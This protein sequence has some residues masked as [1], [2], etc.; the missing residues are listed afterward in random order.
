MGKTTR[1]TVISTYENILRNTGATVATALDLRPRMN[2]AGTGTEN[3]FTIMPDSISNGLVVLRVEGAPNLLS[4]QIVQFTNEFGNGE[5]GTCD[6][7]LTLRDNTF[8]AQNVEVDR[9]GNGTMMIL[10]IHGIMPALGGKC[11]GLQIIRADYL[12]ASNPKCDHPKL[13]CTADLADYWQKS[14]PML[15]WIEDHPNNIMPNVYRGVGVKK[16]AGT[17]QRVYQMLGPG[18]VRE[19][20][21]QTVCINWPVL[22]RKMQGTGTA[23]AFV[24]DD[25]GIAISDEAIGTDGYENLHTCKTISRHAT[26]V[27]TGVSLLGLEGDIYFISAPYA[28]ICDKPPYTGYYSRSREDFIVNIA[29]I[30]P[31]S[32]VFTTF[33]YPTVQDCDSGCGR[34]YSFKLDPYGETGGA[35]HWSL[36]AI[37][38][39]AEAKTTSCI[40]CAIAF[41]NQIPSPQ[42]FGLRPIYFQNLNAMTTS[43]GYWFLGDGGFAVSYSTHAGL[44]PQEFSF[45]FIGALDTGGVARP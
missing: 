38:A 33:P 32:Y 5:R 25:E 7:K 36:T 31:W 12:N 13:G 8:R 42:L 23:H 4:N 35:Y 10:P 19:V 3:P 11:H 34:T 2:A 44:T 17:E 27:H 28:C 9:S 30:S 18:T 21:G 39:Q 41:R 20:S 26:F 45:D 6:E 15:G 40:N 37:L 22:Q 14:V 1:L 43:E 24:E 29:H 16:S